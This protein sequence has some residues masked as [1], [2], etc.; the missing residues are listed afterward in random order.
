VELNHSP[1]IP[2]ENVP[3]TRPTFFAGAKRDYAARIELY[4]NGMRQA[5]E[6]GGVEFTYREMDSGH[7]IMLEK[8]DEVNRELAVWLEGLGL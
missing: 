6:Q 5:C 8:A 7:W 2:K 1:D 4:L 3:L